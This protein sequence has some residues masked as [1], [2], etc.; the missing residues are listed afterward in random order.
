M[1]E[2]YDPAKIATAIQNS[3]A[4]AIDALRMN[5]AL[6]REE[7]DLLWWVLGDWSKFA[8]K[9]FSSMNET[10]A[11]V[12]AGFEAGGVIRRIPSEAHKQLI[13]R[14]LKQDKKASMHEVLESL[15]DERGRIA[16]FFE[17]NPLL[18]D[19]ESLFPLVSAC[20]A[21]KAAGKG[22]GAR[23][24]DLSDWAARALLESAIL[25]VGRLPR[26]LV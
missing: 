20:L 22:A 23:S 15:K 16:T 25:H 18:P 9:P 26:N 1:P 10:A 24:L 6:D 11:V 4:K 19:R 5:A 8:E 21:G 17:N 2:T 7:I 12:A 3:A 13:L 14:L